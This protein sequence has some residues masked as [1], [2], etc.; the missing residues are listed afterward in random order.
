MG[1]VFSG[2][3]LNVDIRQAS[4][5]QGAG[6]G[7]SSEVAVKA[8]PR[9]VIPTVGALLLGIVVALA[10]ALTYA[11]HAGGGFGGGGGG[12]GGGGGGHVGGG[13]GHASGGGR[14]G[15]GAHFAGAPHFGGG[16]HYAG[17]G[18]HFSGGSYGGGAHYV[19]PRYGTATRYASGSRGYAAAHVGAAAYTGRVATPV[20]HAGA[21]FAPATAY[22]HGGHAWV[23]GYWHGVFWPHCW[24]Y[25][26]YAWYLPVLPIGYATFWWGGVPYYY[27]NS[28]Y[29]TWSPADSGYVVTDPP[30]A[31]ESDDSQ[32]SQAAPEQYGSTGAEV[33]LYP[34]NGQ[35]EAQMQNDR[36]ECHAWSVSQTGFDP[37]RPGGP[38]NLGDY[39]RALI[40]CL[41]A[42]GY[43]AR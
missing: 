26:G 5:L 13:G 3:S 24:F 28:L 22:W 30:P 35:S 36:Y 18:G 19:A 9:H 7:S 29:Y 4:N 40:A 15:G 2:M 12:H 32:Y 16:G 37:T 27:W 23:G 1:C 34:R 21:A 20:S 10:P 43:S 14:T 6:C 39:R 25:P 33:Y 31:A 8:S 41:D 38:G 42:R 17:A 11:Q